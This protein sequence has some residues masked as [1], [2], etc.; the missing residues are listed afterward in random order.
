[1]CSDLAH[2]PHP[3]PTRTHARTHART[4]THARAPTTSLGPPGVGTQGL[5]GC[6]VCG[7]APRLSAASCL[8]MAMIIVT[9]SIHSTRA[10]PP[11]LLCMRMALSF[12]PSPS[13]SLPLSLIFLQAF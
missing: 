3:A 7:S 10:P 9:A 8:Q 2:A 5:R 6:V 11:V 13:L 4:R 12:S 1:L